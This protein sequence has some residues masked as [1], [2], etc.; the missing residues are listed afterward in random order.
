MATPNLIDPNF[1][2]SVVF[3]AH[4]DDDGAL[5]VVLN[6]RTELPAVEY[7]APWANVIADPKVIFVG[8]PVTPEIAVGVVDTPGDPPDGWSPAL[9]NIGLF[10]VSQPPGG[11]GGVLRA[12]V[13]AGYAGWVSGQLEAEVTLASWFVVD[14]EPGD[15]FTEEPDGLWRA[16]LGRQTDVRS[17]FANYPVDPRLN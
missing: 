16:V 17:W 6:R 4:H 7:V 3:I 12:R 2:R 15:V 9:A 8:G 14:A 11:V 5:G 13:F 10:D 1:A